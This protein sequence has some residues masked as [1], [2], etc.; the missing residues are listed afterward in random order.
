M[1]N[2]FNAEIIVLTRKTITGEPFDAPLLKLSDYSDHNEFIM[3]CG[4]HFKDEENPDYIFPDWENIP[5]QLITKK[6]LNPAF[7]EI[8]DALERL[9]E[10]DIDGFISW[11]GY[12]GHDLTTDDP[13]LLVTRYEDTLRPTFDYDSENVDYED[14]TLY[15]CGGVYPLSG[16]R[17]AYPEIFND[18]YY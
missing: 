8:R 5:E 13:L 1:R 15:Y 6:Y 10:E 17:N 2:I 4:D 12:N 11:C 14:D 3:A 9:D 7:F 16:Q 18:N